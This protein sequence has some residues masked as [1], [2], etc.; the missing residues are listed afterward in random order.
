VGKLRH[1]PKSLVNTKELMSSTKPNTLT[2]KK[3]PK[4]GNERA[5]QHFLFDCESMREGRP[6]SHGESKEKLADKGSTNN[7]LPQIFLKFLGLQAVV[8]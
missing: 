6:Y 3:S 2:V 7:C 8:G 1:I 5:I 4:T